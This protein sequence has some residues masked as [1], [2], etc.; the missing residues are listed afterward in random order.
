MDLIDDEQ[1]RRSIQVIRS[2][3]ST[4]DEHKCT[5]IE[6]LMRVEWLDDA[7]QAERKKMRD[8]DES[9]IGSQRH[10]HYEESKIGL[11]RP[12]VDSNFDESFNTKKCRT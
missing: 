6:P 1:N 5:D 2:V 8:E 9:G 4:H 3:S 11:K 10:C 7:M 12:L